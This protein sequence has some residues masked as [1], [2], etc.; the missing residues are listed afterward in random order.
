MSKK[1]E[2]PNPDEPPRCGV[3]GT[4]FSP[5][6]RFCGMCGTER[7]GA[8]DGIRAALLRELATAA[9]T[10]VSKCIES[11]M[12]DQKTVEIEIA[13]LVATRLVDWAK[14]FGFWVGI[15]LA[16]LAVVLAALG[17]RTYAGFQ[18]QVR[19]SQVKIGSV[20]NKAKSD[21]DRSAAQATQLTLVLEKRREQIGKLDE[22]D[23]IVASLDNIK[24][25]VAILEKISF[26]PSSAM[27]PELQA[28]LQKEIERFRAYLI[29]LGATGLTGEI[30]VLVDKKMLDNVYFDGERIVLGEPHARDRDAIFREYTNHVLV[31]S[32]SNWRWSAAASDTYQGLAYGLGDY[33]PC[34]FQGKALFGEEFAAWLK[35]NSPGSWTKSYLRNLENHRSLKEFSAKK[36]SV[37]PHDGGEIWGGAF[38]EIRMKTGQ[39]VADRLLYSAWEAMTPQDAKDVIDAF[40][41]RVLEADTKL[42]GGIHRP[43]VVAVF[44]SRG[45]TLE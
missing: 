31:G 28:F 26:V 38:W 12:K 27:T 37:E 24:N 2:N 4:Q 11:R 23:R 34:S 43:V 8:L 32:T 18:D 29:Q 30:K 6:Q 41:R 5:E 14:L 1:L 25:R 9:Q 39:A 45:A 33:F 44:R 21:A 36:G 20:L 16:L 10:E 3:C 42:F 13:G 7:P 22:L 17:I 19:E 35:K 15:P 40:P